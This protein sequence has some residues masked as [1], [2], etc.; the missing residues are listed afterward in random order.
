M[1]MIFTVTELLTI[2]K[3]HSESNVSTVNM[4]LNIRLN[5]SVNM[6]LNM[7]PDFILVWLKL[8]KL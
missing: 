3:L 4:K 8:T 6:N 7:N 1:L 2:A 5:M